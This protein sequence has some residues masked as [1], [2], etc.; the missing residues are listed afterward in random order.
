MTRLHHLLSNQ[1]QIPPGSGGTVSKRL[2][3]LFVSCIA[4]VSFQIVN[5]ATDCNVTK[6]QFSKLDIELNDTDYL[7][8]VMGFSYGSEV[9]NFIPKL[10]L[11]QSNMYYKDSK[12]K[13]LLT[14]FRAEYKN[15]KDAIEASNH[16]KA[17]WLDNKNN[18]YDVQQ[19]DSVVVWFGNNRL[20]PEC[21]NKVVAQEK[22]RVH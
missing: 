21:F 4:L 7:K 3:T 2:I 8:M 20:E 6:W 12:A 14:F 22:K 19:S 1:T 13:P 18:Q 5:A 16:L 17:K 10:K 15:K 11:A 9:S